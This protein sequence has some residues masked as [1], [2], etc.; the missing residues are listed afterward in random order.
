MQQLRTWRHHLL[1]SLRT[2]LRREPPQG[3]QEEGNGLFRL[4]AH[5]HR[6]IAEMFRA[7]VVGLAVLGSSMLGF[8]FY[9]AIYSRTPSWFSLSLTIGGMLL[10]FG[11][12]R[13]LHEFLAYRQHY[14]EV[15]TLLQNRAVE[16]AMRNRSGVG[17]SQSVEKLLL[18][19]RPPQYQGWD[20]KECQHCKH[21]IE[22][23]SKVCAHCGKHQ[24]KPLAN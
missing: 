16:Q 5:Q 9:T 4:Y 3:E 11:M 23:L 12:W 17:T 19:L 2:V 22:L 1:Q 24:F 6:L 10:F 15:R 13:T 21:K 18:S 14:Q 20:T 7:S 8:A